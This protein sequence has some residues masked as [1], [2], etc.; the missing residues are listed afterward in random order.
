[1]AEAD[2]RIIKLVRQVDEERA[3]RIAAERQ[4]GV[5]RAVIARMQA[6]KKPAKQTETGASVSAC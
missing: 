2:V 1:M 6:Q 3:R 5:L 4:A